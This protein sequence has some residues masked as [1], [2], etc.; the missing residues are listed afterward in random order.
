M[1]PQWQ[2][3]KEHGVKTKYLRTVMYY[4]LKNGF[5]RSPSSQASAQEP[6]PQVTCTADADIVV[7]NVGS[8]DIL[9]HTS[10][11]EL[12]GRHVAVISNKE[13]KVYYAW[14]HPSE[15][16]YMNSPGGEAELAE[17]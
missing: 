12:V 5:Q 2:Q 15:V 8:S 9:V 14:L 16:D 7:A 17:R 4:K 1:G 13:A 3:S 11:M 6:T 10:Y